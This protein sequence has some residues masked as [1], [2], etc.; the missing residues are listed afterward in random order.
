MSNELDPKPEP[1][2]RMVYQIRVNGHLGGQWTDWFDGLTI[3]R[4]ENGDTL[5]S[6]PSLDQATLYGVLRKMR[7]LGMTIVSVNQVQIQETRQ[8]RSNKE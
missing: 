5:L 3:T 1:G 4:E 2:Q 8:N 6:G 7:D